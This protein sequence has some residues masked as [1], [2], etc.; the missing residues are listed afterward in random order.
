MYFRCAN[1]LMARM[2][3]NLML[4]SVHTQFNV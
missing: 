4:E 1:A 3:M 2:I